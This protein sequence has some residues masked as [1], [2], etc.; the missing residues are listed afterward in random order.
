MTEP[1]QDIGERTERLFTMVEDLA[2][3]HSPDDETLVRMV[4]LY[5]NAFARFALARAQT[6][7]YRSGNYS[8]ARA[9]ESQAVVLEALEKAV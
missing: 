5:A 9:V 8:A 6:N 7:L 2:I 3:L 1:T 4:K